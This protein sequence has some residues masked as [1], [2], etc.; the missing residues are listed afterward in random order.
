[1]AANSSVVFRILLGFIAGAIAV[2]TVHQAI[3]WGLVNA[4]WL[5][6]TAQPWNMKPYGPLGVPTIANSMFW[7]GLWGALFGLIWDKLP[8]GAIWVR[9]LVF[10][11]LITLIS[12]FTLLPIIRKALGVTNP[13]QIALFAGGDPKRMLA[14]ALI[15]G[16]FGMALAAIYGLMAR[17]D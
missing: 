15:L 8:G 2:A 16:G 9:G 12:N 5:P 14:V 3:V 6:A 4:A 7:G 11:L 17:R 13:A 10:G 1:M